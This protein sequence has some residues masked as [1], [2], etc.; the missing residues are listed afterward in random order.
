MNLFSRL[1]IPQLV[2]QNL[3]EKAQPSQYPFFLFKHVYTNLLI[4]LLGLSLFFIVSFRFQKMSFFLI[5]L[6]IS[7]L[8]IVLGMIIFEK[9]KPAILSRLNQLPTK[10]DNV[11]NWVIIYH[12]VIFASLFFI[13][14]LIPYTHRDIV[15]PCLGFILMVVPFLISMVCFFQFTRFIKKQNPFLQSDTNLSWN[16]WS[17]KSL[18]EG[19][20]DIF[21]FSVIPV[22]NL[23]QAPLHEYENILRLE[24]RTN[25]RIYG[26]FFLFI[27]FIV[28]R[29]PF[30]FSPLLLITS[31]GL[32]ISLITSGLFQKHILKG[33]NTPTFLQKTGQEYYP[34]ERP[35]I[36]KKNTIFDTL[37]M[38]WCY[39][40]LYAVIITSPSEYNNIFYP[41]ISL[42][43]FFVS[44]PLVWNIRLWFYLKK[45]PLSLENINAE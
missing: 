12:P 28:I 13:S 19:L 11:F 43:L 35:T 9:L 44:I 3:L 22:D 37:W 2:P 32:L 39:A 15:S 33:L 26:F 8:S 42:L 25:I 34:A 17:K 18:F 45:N 20:I 36:L 40:L 7:A 41:L 5:T 4:H 38:F 24:L 29:S 21:F 23:T 31:V 30:Y 14:P 1:L 16:L 27:A 6:A 10:P